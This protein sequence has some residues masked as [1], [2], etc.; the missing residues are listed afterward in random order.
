MNF[1]DNTDMALEFTRQ[2]TKKE[3]YHKESVLFDINVTET[4]VTKEGSEITGKPDG[5]YFTFYCGN[6]ADTDNQIKAL[7]AVLEKLLPDGKCLVAGLGNP[8]VATDSLGWIT[9][10]KIL[11]T[12]LYIEKNGTTDGIGDISVIRTNVSSNSGIES[13]YTAK[14]TASA[15]KADYIVAI[16]S[17]VCNEKE[18][19]CRTIQ[20]ADSGISPG[21]GIGNMRTR[22]DKETTG[23]PVIAIGAPTSMPYYGSNEKENSLLFVTRHDIDTEIMRY[24]YIISTALNRALNPML[25][26]AD[27]R[28]LMNYS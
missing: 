2:K 11:A 8:S 13:A 26:D 25:G 21:S 24:S 20:L 6:C 27:I 4:I 28:F 5:R 1:N 19:L 7:T 16:D 17:L 23:V 3:A 12:S 22:L 14:Y 18:R 15:I 10:G 9:A